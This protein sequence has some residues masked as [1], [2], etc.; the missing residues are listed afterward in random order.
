MKYLEAL[1]LGDGVVGASGSY[2]PDSFFRKSGAWFK[3]KVE[4]RTYQD[5]LQYIKFD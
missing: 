1:S 4:K 2:S 5:M 3:T